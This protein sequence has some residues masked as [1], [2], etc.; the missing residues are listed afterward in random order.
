M[1]IVILL[2]YRFTESRRYLELLSSNDLSHLVD[3]WLLQ[4]SIDNYDK[5]NS[6]P[7]TSNVEDSNCGGRFSST[8][9]WS[10]ASDYLLWIAT[11]VLRLSVSD[12]TTPCLRLSFPSII[13][14]LAQWLWRTYFFNSFEHQPTAVLSFSTLLSSA[15]RAQDCNCSTSNR[16][17]EARGSIPR[18]ETLILHVVD[19]LYL[20]WRNPFL[21]T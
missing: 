16:Y 4:P 2:K 6:N 8:V 17:L 1:I 12:L 15:G 13:K 18:G 14:S 7:M 11:I 9:L 5:P 10:K 20:L 21:R 3:V 19:M